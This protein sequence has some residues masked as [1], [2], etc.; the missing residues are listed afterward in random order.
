M[1]Y[2]ISVNLEY[3]FRDAGDTI[4]ERIAAAALTY[5]QQLCEDV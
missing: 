2:A 5:I 1:R 3:A 4:P